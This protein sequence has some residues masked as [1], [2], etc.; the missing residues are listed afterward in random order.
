VHSLDRQLL[1]VVDNGSCSAAPV[2]L[3]PAELQPALTLRTEGVQ[4]VA[5]QLTLK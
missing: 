5:L 1:T 4:V 3:P 2:P